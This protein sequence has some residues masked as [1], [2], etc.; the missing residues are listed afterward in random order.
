MAMGNSK[1]KCITI[2]AILLLITLNCNSQSTKDNKKIKIQ[3]EMEQNKIET[4]NPFK[5]FEPAKRFNIE[6][7]NLKSKGKYECRFTD[8]NGMEVHQFTYPR[9]SSRKIEEY[10]EERNYPNSE[11]KFICCYHDNGLLRHK[12][13]TFYDIHLGVIQ[14]YDKLGNVVREKNWDAPY[15]FSLDNLI[16]KMKDEYKIDIRIPELMWSVYRYV[17]EEINIP[18]YE[19]KVKDPIIDY[20]ILVY[21]IDGNTGETLLITP[22][23]TQVWVGQPG[24]T[25]I[26][27]YIRKRDSGELPD[28]HVDSLNGNTGNELEPKQIEKP[29]EEIILK[30]EKIQPNTPDIPNK[31]VE[32]KK[33]FKFRID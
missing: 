22:R 29:Q 15:T 32:P 21:L 13:T 24:E 23:E 25:I 14:F 12:L 28:R 31:S 26:E 4:Y 17:S 16:D 9:F 20:K 8:D 6:E 11:Y 19:V 18:L 3:K 5:D 33:I 30:K 1:A 7:Y 10:W 2:V 27:E